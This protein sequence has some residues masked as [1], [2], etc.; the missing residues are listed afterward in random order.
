MLSAA[1]VVQYSLVCFFVCSMTCAFSFTKKCTLPLSKFRLFATH[2][3][4]E[5]IISNRGVGSRNEVSKL[6]KQRRIRVDG[7]VIKSGA[8]KY[9]V[10][11]NIEIDGKL[12]TEVIL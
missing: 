3:R 12:V 8:V 4:L 5:R 11:V 2:H 1:V 6:L 9:P 10:D 7:K